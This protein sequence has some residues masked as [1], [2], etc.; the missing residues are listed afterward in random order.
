MTT[1]T[2]LGVPRRLADVLAH[3]GITS[4]FPIQ[5]ATIADAM[6][7]R[8]L[9]GRAPTGSGK[10][11]AFAVPMAALAPAGQ[12]RRPSALVLVPTRE[13]AAQVAETIRPLAKA[14]K[15]R[16]ATF[17]GG[18][19]IA[20]DI[21]AL[22]RGVDIAIACPGRLADLVQRG[23]ADLGATGLVVVDEA[24]RMADMGFLPEVRRL[25][26]R[27]RQ[28]RQTLLF[29]A[30][31]DGDV[32]VLINRYQH[33]PARHEMAESAA[34]DVRHLFWTTPAP[35][36][37]TLTADIV[38]N[39]APALVFTRT[40]RA[41]DRVAKQLTRRGVSAAAIHGDRSQKQRERALADFAAHRVTALVATDVAARGI[42]V[43]A[44]GVVVH[45]DPA[46]TSKDYVHRSGRTGRA[47]ADGIVITL[48]APDKA[49]D[50]RALQKALDVPR[51]TEPPRLEALAGQQ[52][53]RRAAV[54]AA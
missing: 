15:L 26:D 23:A 13:L 7:G 5:S 44:V 22:D 12:P 8:D 17:Y 29:S 48:V 41:A 30:T 2:D 6:A 20:K 14:R 3:Q 33:D 1:F 27:T 24:D 49:G 38:T 51:S 4:P 40:K 42:D 54:P 43:D 19:P 28:D 10:T 47:G 11:L 37:L 34:G 45:Y 9:C 31:L 32:D 53:V 16:T 35:E 52:P 39:A 36:R 25:L 46:P 50:V 18:T 21:A